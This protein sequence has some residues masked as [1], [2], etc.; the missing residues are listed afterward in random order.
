MYNY[1]L[2]CTFVSS[3]FYCLLC[4]VMYHR[5]LLFTAVYCYVLFCTDMYCYEQLCAVQSCTVQLRVLRCLA[6]LE[7]D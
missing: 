3:V 1:V 4:A 5:V 7:A 2:T 6:L